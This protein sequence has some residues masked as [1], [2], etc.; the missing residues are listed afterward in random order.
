MPPRG[1]RRGSKRD[2]QYKEIKKGARK[3]GR[4]EKRAE[5]KFHSRWGGDWTAM[6]FWNKATG[7]EQIALVKGR[8]DPA[9]P[10]LVRMHALNTFTDLF[11]ESGER[12]ALL[13]RSME[14]IAEEGAGIIVVSTLYITWRE[15]DALLHRIIARS[16]PEGCACRI[17]AFSVFA[18]SGTCTADVCRTSAG[19]ES[20]SGA[21]S[22]TPRKS[23][24]G[25]AGRSMI[26]PGRTW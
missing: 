14:I 15:P 23:N 20:G 7:S 11:G 1:V 12:S 25:P 22:G 8:V 24:A 4:S 3:Q 26:A 2:R 18:G 9:K 19:P 5:A 21:P 16:G 13:Q 10:T 6:T 17:G